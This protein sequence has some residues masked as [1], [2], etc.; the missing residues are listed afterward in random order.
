MECLKK[1]QKFRYFYR[2]YEKV[3]GKKIGNAVMIKVLKCLVKN[4][5][6]RYMTNLY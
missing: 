5:L 1:T 6:V 4:R 3:F 2:E